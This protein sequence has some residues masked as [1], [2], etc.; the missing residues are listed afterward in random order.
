MARSP[1][2][3]DLVYE[4]LNKQHVERS[5]AADLYEMLC[6]YNAEQIGATSEEMKTGAVAKL[7]DWLE[8]DSLD[9]RVLAVH[10][11]WEITGK[12][13]MQNPAEKNEIVRNQNIRRWQD[14]LDSGELE[15]VKREK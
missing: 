6:G 13:L 2:S 5:P 14:R 12:Q 4:A 11:L 1:E 8:K 3:A 15:I 9:Y 7:I 10:N